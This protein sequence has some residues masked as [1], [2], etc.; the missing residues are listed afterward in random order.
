MDTRDTTQ[1]PLRVILR[2]SAMRGLTLETFDY[3]DSPDSPN[4]IYSTEPIYF[5][6]REYEF[7]SENKTRI[8]GG[9]NNLVINPD[10]G[11]INNNRTTIHCPQL[12]EC[13]E[14][15]VLATQATSYFISVAFLT[16]LT[17]YII[18]KIYLI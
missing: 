17:L 7:E 6:S 15:C 3:P 12:A 8:F 4:S 10:N 18:I 9:N 14:D 16:L 1:R 11:F 5:S 2:P 13:L